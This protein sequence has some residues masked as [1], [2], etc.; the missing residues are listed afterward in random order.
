MRPEVEAFLF[1]EGGKIASGVVRALLPRLFTTTTKTEGTAE[2]QTVPAT[3]VVDT[4]PAVK[5]TVEPVPYKMEPAKLAPT[6][7][8]AMYHPVTTSDT[9]YRYECCLKHLGAAGILLRESY[10]RAIG[11]EGVG[12]GTGEKVMAALNEHAGMDDDLKAMLTNPNTLDFAKRLDDGVRQLRRAAWDC[13]ITVGKGT[14]EDIAAAR[15][16]NDILF[17]EVYAQVK[18][19]PGQDCI[20]KGM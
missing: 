2:P 7:T 6:V 12:D 10:E 4:V 16:W 20:L 18:L 17:S 9:D 8:P 13:R 15:Q 19:H 5:V 3:K 14:A 11:P 1:Q